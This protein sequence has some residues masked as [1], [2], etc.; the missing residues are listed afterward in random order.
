MTQWNF[1]AFIAEVQDLFDYRTNVLGKSDYFYVEADKTISNN[2]GGTTDY[3]VFSENSD[4]QPSIRAVAGTSLDKIG[5]IFYLIG[6]LG[7]KYQEPDNED[8]DVTTS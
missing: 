8:I 6:T 7:I 2:A 5:D 1:N 3:V 4:G